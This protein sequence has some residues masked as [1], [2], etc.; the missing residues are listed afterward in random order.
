[1]NDAT[2]TPSAHLRFPLIRF[3]LFLAV[4]LV[5]AGVKP[6]DMVV[7]AITAA[8]ATL[9]SA[10]LLP[11]GPVKV[12][13]LA[14]A[15]LV[16]R[17]LYQS[18]VAGVDVAWRALDPR[19]P[20]RPGFVTYHPQLPAGPTRDAFCTVTSLLPGTL[21]CGPSGADGLLVH[22]LDVRQPMV[23]QLAQEEGLFCDALGTSRE[24]RP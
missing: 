11:A 2:E 20:L 13:P 8:I 15:H 4:W 5:I 1:M 6:V 3:V 10:Q 18:V 9:V 21:P 19:L 23:E 22:C 7:G 12:Q 14:F 24:A 16:L 17:F